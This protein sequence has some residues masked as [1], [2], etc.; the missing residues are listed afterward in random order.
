MITET[1]LSQ[2][3]NRQAVII[4]CT[5]IQGDPPPDPIENIFPLG[6]SEEFIWDGIKIK[7]YI[8]KKLSKRGNTNIWI[9]RPDD[10][11]EYWAVQGTMPINL[12]QDHA[13]WLR[14][15]EPYYYTNKLLRRTA[16]QTY[17]YT[18]SQ[19]GNL[20]IALNSEKDKMIFGWDKSYEDQLDD[21]Y[22]KIA[23][24]L[25]CAQDYMLRTH[26][27]ANYNDLPQIKKLW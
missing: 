8:R 14:F 13:N 27:A 19:Y 2:L 20:T 21:N 25:L 4:F 17:L 6:W 12:L 1:V 5:E 7:R 22:L 24:A 10:L 15:Y 18:L 26:V 11:F 9:A 3:F 23:G 16:L